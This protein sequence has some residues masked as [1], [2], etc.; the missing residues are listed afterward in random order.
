MKALILC[1]SGNREGFT[2]A[3]CQGAERA[4]SSDG[5]DVD[6]PRPYDMDVRHCNG[7]LGCRKDGR[8]VIDDDMGEVYSLF[9]GA[10]LLIL[11]TPIQFSGPSSVLKTVVDRFNP[12]WYRKGAHPSRCAAMMCGGSESP[13]FSNTVSILKAFSATVGMEWAGEL[14]LGGTDSGDTA[15]YERKAGEFT[16]GISSI[17][18]GTRRPPCPPYQG[19]GNRDS[20]G[21][22]CNGRT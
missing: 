14:C 1:G 4:L 18:T 16:A 5:W 10:D 15:Y 8:C 13:R 17:R 21:W 7:C 6:V 2:N 20:T 11:A 3:M 12:Y 9:E 22:S 19:T